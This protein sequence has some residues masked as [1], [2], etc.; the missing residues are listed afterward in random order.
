MNPWNDRQENQVNDIPIRNQEPEQ[1]ADQ[2][3]WNEWQN[4]RFKKNDDS[5]KFNIRQ[6]A[7]DVV[8]MMENN[9]VDNGNMY[10]DDNQIMENPEENKGEDM[11][12]HFEEVMDNVMDIIN[13]DQEKEEIQLEDEIEHRLAEVLKDAVNEV[14]DEQA[15]QNQVKTVCRLIHAKCE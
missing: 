5:D 7:N 8:E 10:N 4:N 11:G 2:G 13:E 6:D 14:A 3:I 15:E 9:F 1:F 12:D